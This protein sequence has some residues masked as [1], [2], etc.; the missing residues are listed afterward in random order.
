[1]TTKLLSI[2]CN[3]A[4][5]QGSIGDSLTAVITLLSHHLLAYGAG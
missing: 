4:L 3:S 5:N 1:M 2:T